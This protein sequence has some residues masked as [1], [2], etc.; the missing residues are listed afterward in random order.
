MSLDNNNSND[1]NLNCVIDSMI[2]DANF[3]YDNG[4]DLYQTLL[5]DKNTDYYDENQVKTFFENDTCLSAMHLNC[6]SLHKN[7]DKVKELIMK[8]SLHFCALTETWCNDDTTDLLQIQDYQFVTNNRLLGR[9]G[10]V[11]FYIHRSC[12]YKRIESLSISLEFLE[13]ITVELTT[14]NLTF[15][16]ICV[17]RPPNTNLNSFMNSLNDMFSVVNSSKYSKSSIPIICLG[18]F[19]L[20]LLKCKQHKPTFEFLSLMLSQLMVPLIKSPTRIT[21]SSRTL[22]DNIFTTIYDNLSFDSGILI[23]DT[24]DHLP[25]LLKIK[26]L[27]D[28]KADSTQNGV[29]RTNLDKN[30]LVA[31]FQ[32]HDWTY[33]CRQCDLSTK[34]DDMYD[35]FIS[36]VTNYFNNSKITKMLRL[37]RNNNPE[38][39][40]MTIGILNSRK[41]KNKLYKRFITNPTPENK[42]EYTTYRNKYNNI[43]RMAK[44]QYYD[45]KFTEYKS[46]SRMTWKTI[47]EV[48]NKNTC[49]SK[50]AISH[51]KHMNED[52]NNKNQIADIFNDFFSN[53]GSSLT[54]KL[55]VPAFGSYAEHLQ[56]AP[57]PLHGMAFPDT[58]QYEIMSAC[59]SINIS[60]AQDC[61]GL[62]VNDV[63]PILPYL[64]IPLSHLFNCMARNSV[65]P[66]KL[67]MARVVP[68]HKN[69]L[70]ENVTNYRPISI[71]PVFSKIFERIIYN[72]IYNY[73][74]N[75][76][77]FSTQQYGFRQ[78]YSTE[79]AITDICNDISQ[80][81]ENKDVGIGIFLDLTKAFDLIDHSILIKKL[82]YYG[83]Q[84]PAIGLLK[85]YLQNRLQCV[86]IVG[87]HSNFLPISIGVPQGSILGPLLFLIFINDLPFCSSILKFILF[88]DDTNIFLTGKHVDTLIAIANDE[89]TKVSH[90][91]KCNKLILNLTKSNYIIFN[92]KHMPLPNIQITIDSI[93]IEQVHE[94]KFLGVLIDSDLTWS[95][96]I[97]SVCLKLSRTL[98]IL[99]K[100][101][102]NL[103]KHA[104]FQ[105]YY[106]LFYSHLIY[107]C[108]IWGSADLQYTDRIQVLQNKALRIITNS[109]R[110]A[111]TNAM[112]YSAG[113]LKFKDI[114]KL[115][116]NLF[117]QKL[118]LN[119]LP[120]SFNHYIHEDTSSYS[121][122]NNILHVYARTKARQR[123]PQIAAPMLWCNLPASIRNSTNLNSF[124][125]SSFKLL[126][127]SYSTD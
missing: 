42:Q 112:F 79:L 77:I 35:E 73:L 84:G 13:T 33:F 105:L 7:F 97:N 37:T 58:D 126:L 114:Y 93:V 3:L 102:N 113:L 23:D 15:L 10:G 65:F 34:V 38:N 1:F 80:A 74:N 14:E 111:N 95:G 107:C 103:N 52:I 108:I 9:G 76:N 12:S 18:D 63:K 22:I 21:E 53:I 45:N 30:K 31:F 66:N 39:K 69:G 5:L 87:N 54:S 96:H 98:G 25:V 28:S 100:I 51:I 121:L 6:R 123:H 17:Y 90:W 4:N 120:L 86:D 110:F 24:S 92:Q 61:D 57:R 49:K 68:I 119:L 127:Q 19:N 83:I 26:R 59:A 27:T 64:Y 41:N 32:L 2:N 71:L 70:N 125:K 72:R 48:M 20:D 46:N 36:I 43:L 122:R 60:H 8:N 44:K 118:K 11:A 117:F 82:Q 116:L 78:K 16:L 115:Q 106:S 50:Q 99:N 94:T 104:L 75:K 124:K 85:S 101:K 62:S 40:W 81:H 91:L 55:T 89:L 47:N 109:N 88:A 67:K 56:K 29:Y